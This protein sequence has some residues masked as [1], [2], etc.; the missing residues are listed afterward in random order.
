VI[1]E[2][3]KSWKVRFILYGIFFSHFDLNTVSIL[4]GKSRLNKQVSE[5]ISLNILMVKRKKI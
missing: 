2:S 4:M 3:L 5:Q 1:Q